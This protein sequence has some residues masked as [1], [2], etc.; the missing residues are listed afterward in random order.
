[1]VQFV[2]MGAA[3]GALV[4]YLTRPSAFL[5][6]Q[7]PLMAVIT[8]GASLRGLDQLLLPLARESFDRMLAFLVVGGIIGFAASRWMAKK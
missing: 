5:V 8:R 6:G 1:M 4:G 2:L 3:L 7:V